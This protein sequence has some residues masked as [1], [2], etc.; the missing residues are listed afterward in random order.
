MLVLNYSRALV[1][2][3]G[4]ECFL[5]QLLHILLKEVKEDLAQMQAFFEVD[6]E[7]EASSSPPQSPAFTPSITMLAH[8]MKGVAGNLACDALQASAFALEMETLSLATSSSSSDDETREVIRPLLTHIEMDIKALE[9]H[10]QTLL[11][12]WYDR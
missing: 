9:C 10:I 3:S 8:R 6:A 12:A 5:R 4:D 2:C 11:H 7:A 1:N